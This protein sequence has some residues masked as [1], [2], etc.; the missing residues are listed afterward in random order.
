METRVYALSHYVLGLDIDPEIEKCLAS[1]AKGFVSPEPSLQIYEMQ[2]ATRAARKSS[3]PILH[4]VLSWPE[5]TGPDAGRFGEILQDFID[6]H[7]LHGFQIFSGLHQD[8]DNRHLH[9]VLNRFDFASRKVIEINGGFTRLAGALFCCFV[10]DKYGYEPSENAAAYKINGNLVLSDHYSV[11]SAS[12][13][14]AGASVKFGKASRAE[15]L[16][17]IVRDLIDASESWEQYQHGLFKTGI[18]LTPGPKGG[19]VFLSEDDTGAQHAVAC[20]RVHH[21][22][23][24]AKLNVRLR[25]AFIENYQ[26]TPVR[27]A[28]YQLARLRGVGSARRG[29]DTVPHYAR[30]SSKTTPTKHH[31]Q[32]ASDMLRALDD[33]TDRAWLV[34][35]QPSRG[36]GARHHVLDRK[37]GDGTPL[38]MRELKDLSRN[39]AGLITKRRGVHV[40]P[41][42][43]GN[44]VMLTGPAAALEGLHAAGCFPRVSMLGQERSQFLF[45]DLPAAK[46]SDGPQAYL[47]RL[48]R[49]LDL[50]KAPHPELTL[51]EQGSGPGRVVMDGARPPGRVASFIAP[52]RLQF[53][54]ELEDRLSQLN[55]LMEQ[56]SAGLASMVRRAVLWR[57]AGTYL[58]EA[59]RKGD[60]H[61]TR[62]QARGEHIQRIGGPVRP[63][64][65]T[66]RAADI[67]DGRDALGEG[68]RRNEDPADRADLDRE[69]DIG[70]SDPRAGPGD[71]AGGGD[72]QRSRRVSDVPGAVSEGHEGYHHP[73]GQDRS[74]P[75]GS[76]LGTRPISSEGGVGRAGTAR[77]MFWCLRIAKLHGFRA[78]LDRA[79]NDRITI[80]TG[81][82]TL[83]CMVNKDKIFISPTIHEQRGDEAGVIPPWLDDLSVK[84]QLQAKSFKDTPPP[85]PEPAAEDDAIDPPRPRPRQVIWDLVRDGHPARAATVPGEVALNA[86][87]NL[88]EYDF[89]DLNSVTVHV[90]H[91][92]AANLPANVRAIAA[93][94]EAAAGHGAFDLS[95]SVPTDLIEREPRVLV[96]VFDPPKGMDAAMYDG[97]SETLLVPVG[98]NGEPHLPDG[99]SLERLETVV[100][101]REANGTSPEGERGPDMAQW[102]QK[103]EAHLQPPFVRGQIQFESTTGYTVDRPWHVLLDHDDDWDLEM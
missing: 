7:A 54:G 15:Q 33:V 12:S 82:G 81:D 71:G 42:L 18:H 63:V 26:P 91:P 59:R 46:G 94:I 69:P 57:D 9:I 27:E 60:L 83:M 50:K 90:A 34:Y 51:C 3:D 31:L 56:L 96:M 89:A 40:Q 66:V 20:S 45:V 5:G 43:S 14:I 86:T 24:Q 28:R 72:R 8:T 48:A 78:K 39:I 29:H 80:S 68:R 95:V 36:R 2:V 22:A 61:D 103:L 100:L 53:V 17:P 19:L 85:V 88:D 99:L 4:F 38:T 1:R 32:E 97:S 58:I 87:A 44:A 6:F 23:S 101:H 79:K 25:G 64:D 41:D 35:S 55:R 13:K 74:T 21:G 67:D 47:H 30:H 65:R 70:H 11:E 52:Y 62:A 84:L 10:E 49:D 77:R 75:E 37:R 92:F 16:R 98:L 93:A 76:A 73:A 102:Q